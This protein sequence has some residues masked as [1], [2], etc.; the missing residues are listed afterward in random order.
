[1]RHLNYAWLLLLLL[2][3][4][5]SLNIEQ[6]QTIQEKLYYAQVSLTAATNTVADLRQAGILK[7]A[8]VPKARQIIDDAYSAIQAGRAAASAGKPTDALSY[9]QTA[10]VILIQLRAYLRTMQ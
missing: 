4:C 10:Q 8:D 5:Q 3:G 1:M 2:A 6:P 9:L 7:E